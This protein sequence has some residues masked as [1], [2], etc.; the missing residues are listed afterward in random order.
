M[1]HQL[2]SL[3]PRIELHKNWQLCSSIANQFDDPAQLHEKLSWKSI[4]NLAPA[5]A[6]LRDLG[7][8]T[9]ND[10]HIDFDALDWWYKLN[11]DLPKHQNDLVILGFDGLAT[12]CEVWLNG[13]LIL[14]SSNMF[15]AHQLQIGQKLSANSNELVMVFRSLNKK[16]EKRLPRPRWRS[17]MMAHQQLR[18]I[19]TTVLGRTPGW[20]PPH[21]LVGPWRSLWLQQRPLIAISSLHIHTKVSD[22][23]GIIDIH[24]QIEGFDQ[25]ASPVNQRVEL[26]LEN[27]LQHWIIS[28]ES[29]DCASFS[30]S[31]QLDKIKLW[32][33]HSHG[34]ANLYSAK[35]RVITELETE[36]NTIE[37]ELGALGFRTIQVDREQGTFALIING[38]SVFCRGA[39]WMPLDPVSVQAT[40]EAYLVALKQVKAAGMN[41]LRISG[42]S[43]YESDLF[44]SLCDQLGIMIWQEFMF[45]GMDY[46]KTPEFIQSVHL[47]ARQQLACWQTHPSLT[48]LC[49]N[50]EVEQQ[51]AMWGADRSLW[52]PALFYDDLAKLAAQWCPTV[53]YWPSAVHEGA[54][55]HQCDNGTTFYYGFGAYL[56]PLEDTRLSNL[57]FA[58]E[59]LAIANIPEASNLKLLPG[60]SKIIPKVHHANWKARSP[61][62]LGGAGWDFDD[63]RDFYLAYYFKVDPLQLRYGD[64]ERYLRLSKI[65]SGEMMAAAFSEWRSSASTCQGALIWFLRDLWPGA[66]WGIIDSQ[67][68]PKSCYYY[69][70]RVLQPLT[71][72]LTSEG[73]NGYFVHLIN[74]HPKPVNLIAEIW[75]YQAGQTIVAHTKKTMSLSPRENRSEPLGLW[76]DTFLDLNYSYR[77]GP[78]IADSIYLCLKTNEGELLTETFAFPQGLSNLSQGDLGLTAHLNPLENGDI[79]VQIN[80]QR[81]ALALHIEAEGFI[82]DDAYF[83]LAPNH[84]KKVILHN[85]QAKPKNLYGNLTAL[86]TLTPIPLSITII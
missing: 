77:F 46:P 53:F 83:H 31:Y 57:R 38:I 39:S 11:F 27:N 8:W 58:T 42:T 20:S 37:F 73:S 4:P 10:N 22:T 81:L 3:L 74:E 14:R 66:S 5:A 17:P 6:I 41:M 56:R 29:T 80:C 70:K 75:V 28:L 35:L 64:Y 63:I 34:D 43:H 85:Q 49:G 61:R 40:P 16:L 23:T 47:E 60:S 68:Q 69:L 86:N 2:H 67:G 44:Y 30:A 1:Y 48:V 82:A 15:Q 13:E 33:P 9:I 79:E 65:T 52:Q 32:W 19:R 54:F 12:L 78:A 55:P 76:F 50:A 24:C 62:D 7:E 25:Y 51:A 71:V 21:P 72:S 18:W 59:C 36:T 26:A 45:A 84:N